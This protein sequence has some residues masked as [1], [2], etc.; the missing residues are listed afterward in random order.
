[1]LLNDINNPGTFLAPVTYSAG[2]VDTRAVVVGDVNNDG[3]PDIV[4]TSNCQML[5]CVDGSLNLLLNKGDGTF[6]SPVS[7]GPSMGGPLA[8]GT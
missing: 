5:T 6:K 4:V 3:W 7:L 1:M 2:G 8:M